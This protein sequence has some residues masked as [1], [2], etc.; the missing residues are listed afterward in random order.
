MAKRNYQMTEKKI[1]AYLKEGRGQG[2]GAEYKPWIYIH[3]F[4]SLGRVHRIL[5]MT[6]GRIHH[7]VSDGEA[8]YFTQ[9]DWL[10]DVVDI[11]EQFPL[12]RDLTYRIAKQAGI[13]HPVTSDGTPYVFT[14][15]F[16]L[17]IGHGE[18]RKLVARTFKQT[19][20]LEN[21]R[22]LEKFEVE[23]RY[24]EMKGV[25]WG[26]VTEDQL[27]PVLINN[28]EAVRGFLDLTGFS[29][30]RSGMYQDAI[31]MVAELVKTESEM[32]L[33]ESCRSIDEVLSANYGTALVA[34]KHLIAHKQ[35]VTDMYDS[36]VFEQRPVSAFSLMS[37]VC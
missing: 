7:L 32:T 4:P 35:V 34:A 19:A 12:D 26:I 25:D 31:A 22:V 5:G 37:E 10:D 13:K 18:N 24:W 20:D 30:S 33:G 14:T 17:V 6:T 8:R 29:E 1:Q 27:N 3:D 9:C 23:R 2:S 16:L 11:R 36:Q 28:V 15:D 21:R